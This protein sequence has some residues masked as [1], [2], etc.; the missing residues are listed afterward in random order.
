MRLYNVPCNHQEPPQGEEIDTNSAG[1]SHRRI[2]GN[3]GDWE[4]G[5]SLPSYTALIHLA[6]CLD[7]SAD[8]LLGLEGQ[9]NLEE[10]LA[11]EEKQLINQIRCLD[12]RDQKDIED[13]AALKYQRTIDHK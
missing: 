11:A 5:K 3:V 9:K 6:K 12:Q 13:F 10:D 7:V 4:T 2:A 8:V 1:C